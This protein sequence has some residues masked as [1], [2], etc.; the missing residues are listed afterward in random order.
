MPRGA[1]LALAASL[2]ARATPSA[3]AR[4]TSKWPR[5]VPAL[6][7]RGRTIREPSGWRRFAKVQVS[8]LLGDRPVMTPIG[9]WILH[10]RSIQRLAGDM[11]L[12]GARGLGA[13]FL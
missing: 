9:R 8:S 7:E 3:T 5:T 6:R 12:A 13:G 1:R 4:R 11:A 2:V 10:E